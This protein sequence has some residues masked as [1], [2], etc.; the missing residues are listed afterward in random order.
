[1]AAIHGCSLVLAHAPALVGDGSKP[2]REGADLAG[3]LR[4]YEDALGYP[5][6]QVFIGNLDPDELWRIERPWW[7]NPVAPRAE[8]PFG[9]LIPQ[10]ELYRRMTE[11]D[12][13]QL[14]RLDGSNSGL[15]IY[16]GDAFLG[17]MASAHDQDESLTASVLL[18]NLACKATGALA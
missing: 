10:R 15:P 5:P 4:T 7:R 13:F 17:S 3:S 14:L 6:H 9:A 11:A 16:D 1:G 8:G 2:T 12:A 18:E